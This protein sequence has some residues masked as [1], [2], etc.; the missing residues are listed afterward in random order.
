MQRVRANHGTL[1]ALA[2]A[3]ASGDGGGGGVGGGVGGGITG[4]AGVGLAEQR[5]LLSKY[6][7]EVASLREQIKRYDIENVLFFGFGFEWI[8]IFEWIFE[9]SSS[10]G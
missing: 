7:T 2:V 8:F 3:S 6:V 9:F 4:V 1:A 10:R 5:A